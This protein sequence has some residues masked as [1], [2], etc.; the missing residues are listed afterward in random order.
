[1]TPPIKLTLLI[2]FSTG[3][4]LLND[5]FWLVFFF[6]SLFLVAF[7]IQKKENII[8][9][10]KPLLFVSLFI[11]IFSLFAFEE[12]G[13][14]IN[15]ALLGSLKIITL[16]LSVFIFTGTTSSGQIAGLFSFLPY[17]LPLVLTLTLSTVPTINKEF[18]SILAAQKSRGYKQ[19]AFNFWK[20]IL[21][22]VVPL[23]HRVFGRSEQV[24]MVMQSRGYSE[25][26]K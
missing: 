9:Y 4:I 17:P 26:S 13:T 1:M 11:F 25:D 18:S 14:G 8:N 7:G 20:N 3:I 23:L 19:N 16:S 6:T 21:P 2:L 5:L 10:L 24:G 15:S 22:L 12:V